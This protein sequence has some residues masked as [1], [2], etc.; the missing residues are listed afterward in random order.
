MASFGASMALR[1]LL[2]FL[3]TSRPAYFSRE[4]QIA[5]RLGWGVRVTPDQLALVGLTAILVLGPALAADAHPDRPSDA[6][7]QRESRRS[8]A[9][10]A[11]TS[12]GSCA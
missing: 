9:S 11:S 1:S 10:R 7:G 3:F 8:R 6:R 4:L 12:T 2:E 5:M